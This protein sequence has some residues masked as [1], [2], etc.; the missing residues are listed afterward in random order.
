MAKIS[1]RETQKNGQSA[2]LN[3]R[4]NLV[5]HGI[6]KHKRF[7]SNVKGRERGEGHLLLTK[8]IRLFLNSPWRSLVR[9][10]CKLRD[11]TSEIAQD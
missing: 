11:M 4:K 7:K 2:K 6:Q 9:F 1:S 5:P 3:S 8:L 10:G